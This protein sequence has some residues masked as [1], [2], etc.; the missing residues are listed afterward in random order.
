VSTTAQFQN[1]LNQYLPNKLLKEEF[2]KRD[3]ILSNVEMDNSWVGGEL[4]VPFKGA[5]A[6]SVSFG[7]LTDSSS[8]GQDKYVR[9]SISTYKEVWGSLYFDHK[10]LMEHNKVSESNLLKM[11]P[12]QV[13]EFMDYMKMV[14]SL[15][16]LN[17]A[18]FA[19]ATANGDSSGN[20]TVDRPERLVINQKVIIDDNDSSPATG[21]VNT[22]NMETGVVNF[23][24]A[25]GGA[26][27][28]D[29]SGYTIAQSTK[30]YFDG[31]QSNGFTALRDSLLSSANSG[32]SSLYGVTKTAYPF[33]Q[34]INVSGSTVSGTSILGPLFNGYTTIKNRG[35]GMPDNLLMSYKNLG[36][37]MK[38]L[39]ANKGAYHITDGTKVNAYGW[40]EINI[41]G[42]KGSVKIVGI[43]EMN[44][45]TI[46]YLDKRA[47][48]IYS[49]GGFRKRQSPDGIEFFE[50]RA[51]SGYA[52]IV[53]VCFFGDIV[54]ERPST[55]GIMYGISY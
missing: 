15:S 32:S 17:G 11:L 12:D 47:V 30:L 6:S 50:V 2:I 52:Y 21:Y 31:S 22:I 26:V 49:N 9:G 44:D 33:T 19:T 53:D 20:L 45:D 41:V 39:E 3:W 48:K 29:L 34:A 5:Q 14:V 8:I 55:C 23:V 42:V 13:E 40:T 28:L 18:S 24:T 7:S 36:T 51:T 37:V 25:R 16:M 54:L 4:I 43:Q 1:M 27:A 46:I 38:E 10:D 35:K